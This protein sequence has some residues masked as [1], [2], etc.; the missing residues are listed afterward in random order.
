MVATKMTWCWWNWTIL[1]IVCFQKLECWGN[2]LSRWIRWRGYEGETGPADRVS[3]YEG[4]CPLHLVKLEK[5]CQTEWGLEPIIS[6]E[7]VAI[8]V[9]HFCKRCSLFK[10]EKVGHE[11]NLGI[12]SW[13]VKAAQMGRERSEV[14]WEVEVAHKVEGRAGGSSRGSSRGY[15]FM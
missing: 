1:G 6:L 3:R 12:I 8:T 11:F 2:N 7:C 15:P 14:R 10:V 5:V 4:P 13:E 9:N